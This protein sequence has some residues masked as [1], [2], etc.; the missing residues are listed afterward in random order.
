M[1]NQTKTESLL[2]D[3]THAGQAFDASAL[4]SSVAV[5]NSGELLIAT[6]AKRLHALFILAAGAGSDCFAYLFE[7]PTVSNAGTPVTISNRRLGTTTSSDATITHTPTLSADGTQRFFRLLPFGQD[8][9]SNVAD[10]QEWILA[11]NT[12]FLLRLTN[13]GSSAANLGM[14]MS[15]YTVG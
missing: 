6:G 15:F 13:K 11:K 10:R 12:T 7:T 3:K 14:G 5:N 8:I 2:H 1:G 9:N 4:F